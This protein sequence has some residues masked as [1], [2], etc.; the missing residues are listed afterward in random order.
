MNEQMKLDISTLSNPLQDDFPS[1]NIDNRENKDILKEKY[2]INKHNRNKYININNENSYASNNITTEAGKISLI[3]N[4][5]NL[6]KS[7]DNENDEYL[8]ILN[9]NIK[10]GSELTLEKSKVIKLKSLL[11]EKEDEN[12]DLKLKI[13]EVEKNFQEIEKDQK[14][15]YENKINSIYKEISV[16]KSHLK[17]TYEAI[18]RCKDREL[19]D[20]NKKINNLLNIIDLFFDLFNNK[21]NLMKKTGILTNIK[22]IHLEKSYKINYKNSLFIIN[23]IDELIKKLFKD[24]KN[25]YD[26]LIQYKEFKEKHDITQ[27]EKSEEEKEDNNNEINNQENYIEN[28]ETDR[29]YNNN[30]LTD[31]INDKNKKYILKNKCKNYDINDNKIIFKS[32]RKTFSNIAEFFK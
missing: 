15:F 20:I 23:S 27:T 16:D 1:N 17:E 28:I 4:P 30:F 24:N 22:K 26:E 9:E 8:K 21:L 3:K 25:L 6:L 10:L 13:E 2:E 29:K 18:Q 19:S 11:K 31:R 7:F 32:H 14:K 12:K 5:P